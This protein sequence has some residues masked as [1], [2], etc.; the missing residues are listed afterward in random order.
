MDKNTLKFALKGTS[1]V[2]FMENIWTGILFLIA[3]FCS[4]AASSNYMTFIGAII[5]V[6][7]ATITAQLLNTN[8]DMLEA[9]LYGFNGVLVGIALPTFIATSPALVFIIIFGSMLSV[10]VTDTFNNS[11]T[12]KLGIPGSTGPFVLC[13]WLMMAC[14]Y[15][16]GYLDVNH[17]SGGSI[18]K[19]YL[20]N[21]APIPG[22]GALIAIFF[23]N[24]GQVFLLGSTISGVIVLI[25]I[26]VASRP[27]GFAA[28][29]GSFIA[30][31][32]GLL[33]GADPKDFAEGLYGFSPVLTAMAVSVI[34]FKPSKCVIVYAVLATI[35]TVLIQGA[36]DVIMIPDGL[37][38]FTA[39]YVLT[40]Y[41]FVGARGLVEP[42]KA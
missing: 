14:A 7:T 8:K 4:S 34:F 1:Q 37:P 18:A 12:K 2:F 40:M 33:M 5:G 22:I 36:L 32:I 23:K 10:V 15:N 30:I 13:G 38:S 35:I 9:G 20:L 19:D 21:D 25:G 31:V 39:P 17:F 11:L 28:A 24:I 6:A 16:F 27:A 3:I 26:F 41:L 29:A 42:P